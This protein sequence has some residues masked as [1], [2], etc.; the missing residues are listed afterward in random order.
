MDIF[1][2]FFIQKIINEKY[3]DACT[4]SK[5][6]PSLADVLRKERI[7]LFY[8]LK[9]RNKQCKSMKFSFL[10]TLQLIIWWILTI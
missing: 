5:R 9:L 1:K 4:Y 8:L 10:V 6:K 7:D 2:G 3:T